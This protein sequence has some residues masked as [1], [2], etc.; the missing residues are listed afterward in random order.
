MSGQQPDWNQL[1]RMKEVLVRD[2]YDRGVTRV[3]FVTAFVEP[4]QSSVWLCVSSDAE[5]DE[6]LAE[7]DLLGVVNAAFRSNGLDTSLI[8]SA[9]TQSQETVSRDYEGSW[10]YALR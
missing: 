6:L 8:D 3:E 5:R 10:F 7:P 4:Y 2:L 1:E 9:T